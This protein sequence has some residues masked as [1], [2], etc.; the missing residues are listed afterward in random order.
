MLRRRSCVIPNNTHR[1]EAG[2]SWRGGAEN[3]PCQ[4]SIRFCS[5]LIRPRAAMWGR[6]PAT[7]RPP[8][9][10]RP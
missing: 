5:R 10:R 1:H 4:I 2:A 7:S 3:R 6:T 8:A 9:R